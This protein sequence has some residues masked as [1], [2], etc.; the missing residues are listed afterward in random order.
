MTIEGGTNGF[1]GFVLQSQ[2]EDGTP[3]GTFYP[4]AESSRYCDEINIYTHTVTHVSAILKY[5]IT[6]PWTGPATYV[7]KVY[8]Q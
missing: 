2:G 3:I 7:Q 8:F 6:I 1:K 4:S 5:N